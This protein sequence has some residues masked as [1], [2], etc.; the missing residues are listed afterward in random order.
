MRLLPTTVRGT[1]LVALAVWLAAGAALWRLLPAQPRCVLPAAGDAVTFLADGRTL[2]TAVHPKYVGREP[3]FQLW[4]TATGR[5]AATHLAGESNARLEEV[6][7]RTGRAVIYRR[8]TAPAGRDTDVERT[9]HVLDLHTGREQPL[10]FVLAPGEDLE[11]VFS[12]DGRHLAVSVSAGNRYRTDWWDLTAGRPVRTLPDGLWNGRFSPDGH[13]FLGELRGGAEDG[14]EVSLHVWEVASGSPG[15]W[16]PVTVDVAARCGFSADGRRLLVRRWGDT[17]VWDWAD[18]RKVLDV[19]QSGGTFTPDGESVVLVARDE[20]GHHIACWDVATSRRRWV[21]R[22]CR[23]NETPVE[24]VPTPAGGPVR[25][26]GLWITGYVPTRVEEWLVKLRLRKPTAAAAGLVH[27]LDPATGR[28]LDEFVDPGEVWSPDGRTVAGGGPGAV[29]VWDVPPRKPRTWWLA[30]AG[31]AAVPVA[32]L[33]QWR[34]R[35]LRAGTLRL[36][37]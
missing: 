24:V 10:P 33:A 27:L 21:S 31:A 34:V 16:P 25:V 4:D 1:W 5:L 17:Q 26:H 9:L 13:W 36:G 3:P 22:L 6:C 29:E 12:P 23:D 8:R 19:P 37:G 35:R 14:P 18:R 15:P 28:E 11:I 2:L 20:H 7:P 30:L 32:G